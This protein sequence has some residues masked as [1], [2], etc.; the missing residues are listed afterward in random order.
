M[1]AAYLEEL[2]ARLQEVLG[3]R[4]TAVYALGGYA[5]GAY[6]AGR[7]DLDVLAVVREPLD[8]DTKARIVERCV[9]EALPCP[10]RKLELVV[11]TGTPRWELNLN[12]GEGERHVG[13]DPD[14]EPAFWFV[15]DLALV[16]EHGLA[17][18]G[19]PPADVLAP[20][21]RDDVV[22]AQAEAIAW[23]AAN[24]PGRDT[25]A[26]AARSWHWL[27][28]GRFAPKDEAVAWAAQRW[29]SRHISA[30]GGPS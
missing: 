12:T 5:L 9:H 15:L 14:A 1:V 16:R 6:V 25:F 28:T 21:A 13:T 2:C 23:Y 11:S 4:L 3:E 24:E 20:V 26:A 18:V 27:E 17:L 10:A 19:P 30:S 7:S 8:E 22:A 29:G